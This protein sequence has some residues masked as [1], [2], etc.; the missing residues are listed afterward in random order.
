MAQRHGQREDFVM[1]VFKEDFNRITKWVLQYP[2]LETGG[3][4]FGLWTSGGNPVIHIVLGP[5]TGCTRTETSF[6]QDVEYLSR[7]GSFLT[8]QYM[9]CHI[10]EWHSHNCMSLS[11]PSRGDVST[12]V[13]NY[14]EGA[15]GFLLMITNIV[16][17]RDAPVKMSPY[18]FHEG[19]SSYRRGKLVFLDG[20]SP[21]RTDE[22]ITHEV[23]QGAELQK[24]PEPFR[25]PEPGMFEAIKTK[26][27]D[28][29]VYPCTAIRLAIANKE[30]D[31]VPME[32]DQ[33]NESPTMVRARS[34]DRR[35]TRTGSL[36]RG[37]KL[38]RPP[39]D[40]RGTVSRQPQLSSLT[41]NTPSAETFDQGPVKA[42]NCTDKNQWYSKK[43]GEKLLENLFNYISRIPQTHNVQMTRDANSQDIF[44]G[45]NHHDANWK[46]AFPSNFPKRVGKLVK[47]VSPVITES[48][49]R[50]VDSIDELTAKAEE[51]LHARIT[52]HCETCG[53]RG[54]VGR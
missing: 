9:L 44:I 25:S 15:S 41:R 42:S 40:P 23:E 14:P 34:P 11:K 26:L 53:R 33:G 8:S 35:Q 28:F 51:T 31:V 47:E 7:V 18:L 10:G 17:N 27:K 13:K 24:Q 46:I 32:I 20:D 6:Y 43:K 16:S 54:A 19:R 4:L 49:F 50:T 12:I 45:F 1:Y 22:R 2:N 29:T 38:T 30:S 5:A 3:S 52:S 48:Y 39:V 21:F 37:Q 36:Q